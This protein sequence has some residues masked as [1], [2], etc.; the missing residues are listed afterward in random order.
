M[1]ILFLYGSTIDPIKGGI[2]RVTNVL[3]S[4]FETRGLKI[5]YL[6]LKKTSQIVDDRQYYLPDSTVFNTNENRQFFL[7][8][9]KEKS[10]DIVINQGGLDPKS[11][12]LAY[13]AHQVNGVKLI[14]AVHNSMLASIKNFSSAYASRLYHFKRLLR[15]TDSK[16]I[17]SILLGLYKQ[18]YKKHYITL[19]KNSDAVVLLSEKFKEELAFFTESLSLDN[20]VGIPNP[21][22]FSE[23]KWQEKKK[24]LLYVGRIDFAQKRVDLLLEIWSK[25]YEE[26]P[27]WLLRI[28]GDGSLDETIQLASK[29]QLRNIYFEGFKNPQ[30]YYQNASLF[31]MTSSF[32]GFGI[33]LVEAMQYGLVPFAFNSYLSVTDIIDNQIN[34]VLIPPFDINKYVYELKQFMQ[35]ESMHIQFSEAAIK[36]SKEFS[37]DVIGNKWI[38]LF[39]QC[40][41]VLIPYRNPESSPVE[42]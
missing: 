36:K 9:L 25:L 38:S 1:N 14:S 8:F 19:C 6:G 2:Q 4:Y 33:V 10:I 5:Y 42:F 27:D 13:Y 32:E 21:V 35:D 18:K 15:Y 40:D 24:E 28:V 16:W 34:G 31:C 29:L 26:Y 37:L 39:E 11:S 22:S 20:V 23:T 17:K 12:E 3:S 41:V 30:I 7:S